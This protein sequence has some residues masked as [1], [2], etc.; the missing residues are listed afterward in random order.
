MRLR[1]SASRCAMQL[2]R[3]RELLRTSVA[4]NQMSTSV[5]ERLSS[6]ARVVM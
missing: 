1:K 4:G 2:L 3:L 6:Q 5:A